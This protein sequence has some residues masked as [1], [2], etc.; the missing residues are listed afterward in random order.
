M[1][2]LIATKQWAFQ[3][4]GGGVGHF[5]S[6][7]C[8]ITKMEVFLMLFSY[9]SKMSTRSLMVSNHVPFATLSSALRLI[10]CPTWSAKHAII[11]STL[12]VYTNGSRAQVK[13]NVSYVSN[14]GQE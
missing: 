14:P 13:A 9:G 4:I 11:A 8:S 7:S 2:R 3:K 12:V 10:I 1:L 5:R 6:C